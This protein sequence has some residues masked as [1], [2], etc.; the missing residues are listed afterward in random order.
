MTHRVI[1]LTVIRKHL[2]FHHLAKMMKHCNALP[3]NIRIID[4][5]EQLI[6]WDLIAGN[7][8]EKMQYLFEKKM[9]QPEFEIE[10]NDQIF[11][12][13]YSQWKKE[14]NYIDFAD[15]I[16]LFIKFLDSD[17]SKLFHQAY[18]HILVDE[19]QDLNQ[20]QFKILQKMYRNCSSL[21]LVGDIAQSIY[22]FRYAKPD[23]IFTCEKEFKLKKYYLT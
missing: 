6:G 4:Q 5:D 9:Y 8:K 18:S 21:T 19:C 16:L 15:I 23:I 20:L 14:N 11:L 13:R 3:K 10:A 17:E 7:F 2:N 12:T 1:Y 22:G